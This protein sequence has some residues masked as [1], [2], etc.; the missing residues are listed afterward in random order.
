M[1]AIVAGSETL[2]ELLVK[3][4]ADVGPTEDGVSPLLLA[5]QAGLTKLIGLLVQKVR[6]A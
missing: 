1:R 6:R 5:C 3:A 2:A 4:G